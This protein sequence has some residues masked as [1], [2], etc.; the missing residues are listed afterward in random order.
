MLHIR[1]HRITWLFACTALLGTS[2]ML[3]GC[4]AVRARRGNAKE[5]GFL[6]DYS[7]L[8]HNKDFPAQEVYINPDAV[9]PRY[10]SV[11]IDSV[12]LWVNQQ[13]GKLSANDKQM[14][15]DTLYRALHQQLGQQFVIAEHPGERV[16]RLRAALTQAKG[17]IV[18]LRTVT[19]FVPQLRLIST[20]V[21]LSADTATTVGSATVE[22]EAVDSMSGVRLAAVVDSRAGTTALFSGRTFQKWGDVEAAADFWAT[23]VT[24]ALVKLGVRRK[25]GAPAVQ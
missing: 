4:G 5:S 15:T 14:L 25:E 20:A 21:G 9:W 6:R 7:K 8:E 17:A 23:K 1:R 18:P 24:K 19:T 3:A 2:I 11:Q 16:L 10:D 13:T 22:V 12:T